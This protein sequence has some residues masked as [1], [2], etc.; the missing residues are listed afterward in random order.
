MER[1]VDNM[2]KERRQDVWDLIHMATCSCRLRKSDYLKLRDLC[3]E[4]DTTVHSLMRA[5][6]GRVMVGAG[7]D[8]SAE[9]RAD[10]HRF[11][12]KGKRRRIE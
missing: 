6:A 12:G 3:K 1:L 8:V 10:L 11:W 5:L 4:H 9:L 2:G 7:V